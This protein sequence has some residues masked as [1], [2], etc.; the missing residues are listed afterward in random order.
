M[1][2]LPSRP[3]LCQHD[4]GQVQLQCRQLRVPRAQ[5]QQGLLQRTLVDNTQLGY[6]G[7]SGRPT[8]S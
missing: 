8:V 6:T 2:L 1:T 4:P 7:G 3:T 5:A